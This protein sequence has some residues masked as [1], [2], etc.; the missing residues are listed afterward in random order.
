MGATP[1]D[2]AL[3]LHSE[4]GD[5]T[6]RVNPYDCRFHA[7]VYAAGSSTHRITAR[8]TEGWLTGGVPLYAGAGGPDNR[9]SAFLR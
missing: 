5:F 6:Y 2:V 1:Q 3:L 7:L 8:S 9:L 4:Q